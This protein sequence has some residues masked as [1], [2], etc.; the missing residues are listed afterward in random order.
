MV[1]V[2]ENLINTAKALLYIVL[3]KIVEAP[4]HILTRIG[5]GMNTS[6]M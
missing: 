5:V 6:E 4:N 2:V 3:A 1:G